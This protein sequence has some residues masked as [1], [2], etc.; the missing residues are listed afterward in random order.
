[1]NQLSQMESPESETPRGKIP[2]RE[3][4]I[5]TGVKLLSRKWLSEVSVADICR[6]AGLSNGVFYRYFQTKEQLFVEI[7][8][9]YFNVLSEAFA[10]LESPDPENGIR[11][12][13]TTVFDLTDNHKDLTSI[14]R[15]GQYRYY[16]FERRIN[17]LYEVTLGRI[18][19]SAPSRAQTIY[20]M[21]GIR[22][23][24]FRRTYHGLEADP[25][26]ITRFLIEGA[27]TSPSPD[28][29]KVF[30]I[31]MKPLPIRLEQTVAEQ[32][33]ASGKG[34]LGSSGFHDVNI[35]QI[36]EKAGVSVGTFYNYFP[37]KEEFYAQVIHQV[38]HELRQAI[39]QNL[40]PGLS[41]LELELQGMV[42]FAFYITNL[43][44]SCYN[45]VR[46][47][48]FVTPTAVRDYYDAFNR[49][50]AKHM[51]GL[52]FGTSRMAGNFLMGLSHYFGLALLHE[53]GSYH[54]IAKPLIRD[55]GTLLI[56]GISSF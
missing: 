13:C 5:H 49:G 48:E 16:D 18:L 28:W 30:N 8:E 26:L 52:K 53:P 1:M 31:E 15:E 9:R 29:Q 41:R 10:T 17:R 34:L 54:S 12:L 37:G 23:L 43:D 19:G 35:H 3:R 4:L 2:T 39:S 46:E 14:F 33:I 56:H 47:G 11:A 21:A 32:L 50:Y 38:S 44:H 24:A 51:D 7:L 45:I 40:S 6:T 25:A 42:L 20:A 36:T 55:L 27:F 22:F